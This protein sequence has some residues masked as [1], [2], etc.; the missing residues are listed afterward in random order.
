VGDL[1]ILDEDGYLFLR[2]RKIDL[3]IA[4]GVNIYP[5]EIEAALLALALCGAAAVR[6]RNRTRQGAAPDA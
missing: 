2:D 1:G 3:I 6:H 5:A 4:G